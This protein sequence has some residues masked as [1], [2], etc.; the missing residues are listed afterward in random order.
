MIIFCS[1]CLIPVS[2]TPLGTAAR[3]DHSKPGICQTWAQGSKCLAHTRTSIFSLDTSKQV[4]VPWNYFKQNP[5]LENLICVYYWIAFVYSFQDI[6]TNWSARQK[7]AVSN[8]ILPGFFLCVCVCE[9]D[10]RC[11]QKL[12]K[13]ADT[14]ETLLQIFVKLYYIPAE[15]C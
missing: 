2:L 6:F 13:K 4:F 15:C 14:H 9:S 5:S 8:K 11:M 12:H 3:A 7:V 10:T 1:C